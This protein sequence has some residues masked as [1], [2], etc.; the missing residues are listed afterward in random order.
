MADT[1]TVA[2]GDTLGRLAARYDTS[3]A[4]LM[5][6]NPQ[7]KDKN[8]IVIGWELT[9]PDGEAGEAE[10]T[11]ETTN[12]GQS[13]NNVPGTPQVWKVGGRSF[14]V[15][16][17]PD[18]EDDP[19][20]MAWEV[21]SD[22]DLEAM[23]GPDQ[24]VVYNRQ[25]TADAFAGLG[26]VEFGTT[27]ELPSTEKD[28]FAAWTSTMESEAITQP[29]ILDDDYQRLAAMAAVEGRG[30]TDSELAQTSWWQDHS[31]AEREWMIL[32]H[33]D[34]AEADRVVADAITSVRATLTSAGAGPEPP[35]ELVEAMAM[36][37]VQGHW[38]QAD[39]NQQI[40]AVT[41]PYS[42][43]K[44]AD[45][46]LPI[47]E[48]STIT[49][50]VAEEDAVRQHL[51]TWLGPAFGDWNDSE[52]SRIAGEIR[53][54]PEREQRFIE[55]LKDQRM[56]LLPEYENREVSYQSIANTWRQFWIGQ[57][58]QDPDETSD[59]WMKVLKNN[60]SGES[61]RLMR[62]EGYHR[63]VQ[64]VINDLNQSTLRGAGGS[65]R[66]GVYA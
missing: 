47:V 61:A 55:E 37:F 30:L 16:T 35:A 39:L 42:N 54:D 65:E 52:I 57:W 48:S 25:I 46:I 5:K 28:P 1:H 36:E 23:F 11:P 40:R 43:I 21:P 58:G 2:K 14:L 34:P 64:K 62:E 31:R 44:V 13:L 12:E 38:S 53:N 26:V 66:R 17:V 8:L 56:A 49:Q 24:P 15:Y 18:T 4:E 6:L 41:D 59:L 29:W 32:K 27:D 22:N 19:V 60:D 63:G 33:G 3:V 9:L 51:N 10:E 45:V 20:F 7:I 50:T